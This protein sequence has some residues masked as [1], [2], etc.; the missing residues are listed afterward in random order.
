MLHHKRLSKYTDHF[1]T[2]K[3]FFRDL[4]DGTLP[5]FT[6]IEPRFIIRSN[7]MHPPEYYKGTLVFPTSIL[8]GDYLLHKVYSA[9]RKSRL[10]NNAML[11]ITFDEAG[12]TYDHVPPPC[13]VSPGDGSEKE[14][15]FSFKRLGERVPT[16][17]I[18][19]WIEKNTVCSAQLQHTSLIKYVFENFGIEGHLTERDRHAS[20]IPHTVFER[21]TPRRNWPKTHPHK[22]KKYLTNA[23]FSM[24][25]PLDALG[26]AVLL[27][28]MHVWAKSGDDSGDER[29]GLLHQILSKKDLSSVDATELMTR[30]RKDMNWEDTIC[31][32]LDIPPALKVPF[33]RTISNK[34]K[35]AVHAVA[36]AMRKVI[37]VVGKVGMK[38]K[39]GEAV[40]SPTEET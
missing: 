30:I 33:T 19:P 22:V 31:T 28:W 9:L 24:R 27:G 26:K 2:M 25:H 23:D 1:K 36:R 35:K 15:N 14:H 12:G 4:K 5:H 40:A 7:S 16:I 10:R 20:S 21:S 38:Q 11:L 6:L 29:E 8:D 13:A 3:H 39:K 18:S 32:A 17:I 37:S 34:V